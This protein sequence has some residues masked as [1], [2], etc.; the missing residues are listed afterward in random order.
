LL[1]VFAEAINEWRSYREAYD[2]FLLFNGFSKVGFEIV[3]GDVVI[4]M[5]E[6]VGGNTAAAVIVV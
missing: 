6:V 2:K 4:E 3:S 1:P 5:T